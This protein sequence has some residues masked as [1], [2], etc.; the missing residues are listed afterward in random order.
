MIPAPELVE[1]AQ[2]WWDVERVPAVV[3]DDAACE[4]H[5]VDPDDPRSR[6]LL[7]RFATAVPDPHEVAA[8]L[9]EGLAACDF[10]PDGA[11]VVPER[12]RVTLRA[13]GVRGLPAG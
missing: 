4:F 8:A 11:G 10:P 3:W 9:A 7:A 13:A 6:L 1:V 5:L 2:I 12:A